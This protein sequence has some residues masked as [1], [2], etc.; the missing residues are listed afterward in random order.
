MPTELRR[1][2]FSN[3]ELREALDA[4]LLSRQESMPVGYIKSAKFGRDGGDLA[5]SLYDRSADKTHEVV[6][7]ASHIA[8]ALIRYC[9]SHHVPLPRHAAKSISVC[10]DNVALD[11][12]RGSR[13]VDVRIVESESAR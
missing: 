12:R 8:A 13:A 11:V 6:L 1:I 7:S 10:G 2:V 4:Y 5:L 3:D 9:F